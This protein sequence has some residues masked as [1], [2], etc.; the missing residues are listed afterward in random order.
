VTVEIRRDLLWRLWRS[1]VGDM[2]DDQGTAETHS[3]LPDDTVAPD[4]GHASFEHCARTAVR[5]D[6]G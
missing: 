4:P 2:K 5:V 3:V 1:P 6:G